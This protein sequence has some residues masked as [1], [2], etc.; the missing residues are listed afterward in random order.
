VG[1]CAPAVTTETGD[2]VRDVEIDMVADGHCRVTSIVACAEGA[3]RA[4]VEE[5]GYDLAGAHR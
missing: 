4:A 1:P 3:M 2:V 5:P